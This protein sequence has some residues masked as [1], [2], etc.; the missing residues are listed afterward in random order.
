MCTIN[1]ITPTLSW[2]PKGGQAIID[3]W[4][5][6]IKQ[7]ETEVNKVAVDKFTQLN[8]IVEATVDK[9]FA[10][11]V[12]KQATI[13]IVEIKE[14]EEWDLQNLFFEVIE[15]K[16]VILSDGTVEQPISIE[17]PKE[18]VSTKAI[19][20]EKQAGVVGWGS[21]GSKAIIDRWKKPDE[22]T[23]NTVSENQSSSKAIDKPKWQHK[24]GEIT[25]K[26]QEILKV[27][28]SQDKIS[29]YTTSRKGEPGISLN[30][31]KDRISK[32]WNGPSLQ[33]VR[34]PDGIITSMD[35]RRLYVCQKIASE[36]P[37]FEMPITLFSH[38]FY[39][40]WKVNSIKGHRD[41]YEGDS[42]YIKR[43][44]CTEHGLYRGS[45]GEAV[46]LRMSGGDKFNSTKPYGF[47][48]PP[49][50]TNLYY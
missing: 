44:D 50:V 3:K 45:W 9:T 2:G 38:K 11:I 28:F 31:L 24:L 48:N 6:P 22:M 43:A 47:E 49:K 7:V 41:D 4:K 21:S 40:K 19:S 33:C 17:S 32:G 12:N 20:E 5:Q 14:E 27:R 16:E 26:G 36:K 23:A 29:P 18:E 37:D 25:L 1:S 39:A 42:Q 10:E 35:N 13:V 15:V 34:M 8:P 46:Y 30:D